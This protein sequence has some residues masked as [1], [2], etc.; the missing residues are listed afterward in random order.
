MNALSTS[1]YAKLAGTSGL[2]SLLSSSTAIYNQIAPQ[3]ATFP[4]VVFQILSE[5]DDNETQNRAKQFLALVKGLS[6]TGFKQAG[7]IDAAID[8]ALQATTITV[9]G[10]VNFMTRRESSTEY[11]EP[12]PGGGNVYHVGGIYRLRLAK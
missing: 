5:V 7:E 2:T 10:W 1:L 12:I 3:G 11:L 9:T 6:N 4:F 8:A